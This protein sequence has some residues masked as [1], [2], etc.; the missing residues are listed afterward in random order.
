MPAGRRGW[1]QVAAYAARDRGRGELPERITHN[2]VLVRPGSGKAV[3]IPFWRAE[4]NNRDFH[5]SERIGRFLESADERLETE[6]LQKELAARQLDREAAGEL[7]SF[8]R[9]QKEAADCGKMRVWIRQ[10][11]P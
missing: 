3:G 5:F 11:F 7:I 10:E 1:G 4:P 8:L 9:S 6:A 2:D